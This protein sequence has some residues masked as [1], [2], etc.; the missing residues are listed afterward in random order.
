MYSTRF[1]VLL[2]EDIKLSLFGDGEWV[3][4]AGLGVR[5][6]GKLD[7]VIPRLHLGQFIKVILGEDRVEMSEMWWDIFVKGC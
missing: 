6:R 3:D 4:L 7:C 2:E 5:V 1:E